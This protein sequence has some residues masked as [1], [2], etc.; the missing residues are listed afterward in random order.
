MITLKNI[1]TGEAVT[2]A[3]TDGYDLELWATIEAPPP[4]DASDKPYTVNDAGEW[5]AVPPPPA[6]ALHQL[7]D[8]L[9]SAGTITA[10]QGDTIK[11]A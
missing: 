7:V 5:V 10:A 2:V 1:E 11:A 9:V 3:S 4:A 6:P 8:M